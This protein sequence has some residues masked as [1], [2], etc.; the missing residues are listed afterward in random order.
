MSGMR[1]TMA[2]AMKNE[3]L[4][5]DFS[6]ISEITATKNTPNAMT[7]MTPLIKVAKYSLVNQIMNNTTVSISNAIQM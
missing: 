1:A 7:K 4:T 6:I 2:I 3:R 5:L